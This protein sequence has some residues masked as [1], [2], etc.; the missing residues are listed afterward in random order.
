MSTIIN[1][2]STGEASDSMAGTVLGI[3]VALVLII[4]FFVYALPAIQGRNSAGNTTSTNGASGGVNI[5]LPAGSTG[6]TSGGT[7]SS[8]P[9][10]Q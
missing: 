4:L 3:V 1:N 9:A 5:N 6:G 7:N 10:T 8:V 2:P